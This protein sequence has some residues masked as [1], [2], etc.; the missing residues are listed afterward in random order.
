MLVLSDEKMNHLVLSALQYS[1]PFHLVSSLTISVAAPYPARCTCECHLHQED[2]AEG[3]DHVWRCSEGYSEGQELE[4]VIN[5][6]LTL[7]CHK[8]TNLKTLSIFVDIEPKE[9]DG[10]FCGC[11]DAS[12]SSQFAPTIIKSLPKTCTNLELDVAG[13]HIGCCCALLRQSLQ[14]LSHLRLR[15]D[16]LY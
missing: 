10:A 7:M 9:S 13:A 8:M 2:L 12:F 11:Y 16:S 14:R 5:R 15:T 1:H 3:I 6:I 4:K